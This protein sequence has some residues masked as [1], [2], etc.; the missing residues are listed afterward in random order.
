MLDGPSKGEEG[1]LY[2]FFNKRNERFLFRTVIYKSIKHFRKDTARWFE[3]PLLYKMVSM[4]AVDK[5]HLRDGDG[6]LRRTTQ[7]TTWALPGTLPRGATQRV[8]LRADR[9]EQVRG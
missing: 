3:M 4:A 8:P 9:V 2:L 7:P 6:R 5:G 1:R